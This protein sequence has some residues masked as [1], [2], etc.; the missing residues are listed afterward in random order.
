MLEDTA[1]A[2][3]GA[4]DTSTNLVGNEYQREEVSEH[5]EGSFALCWCPTFLQKQSCR[6]LLLVVFGREMANRVLKRMTRLKLEDL[7]GCF[8]K[9][10]HKPCKNNG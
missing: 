8:L 3:D 5:S 2:T 7:S 6:D 1:G 4:L 10:I 9:G